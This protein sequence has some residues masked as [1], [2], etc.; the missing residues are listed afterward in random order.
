MKLNLKTPISWEWKH[1]ARPNMIHLGSLEFNSNV[2]SL[3]IL[4]IKITS[5]TNLRNLWHYHMSLKCVLCENI[6]FMLLR[7]VFYEKTIEIDNQ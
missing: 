4:R 1:F 7:T 5:E 2:K 3:F 6:N